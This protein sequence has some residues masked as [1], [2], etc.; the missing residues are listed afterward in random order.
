MR[1]SR[2]QALEEKVE[3]NFKNRYVWSP[4]YIDA[5]VTRDRDTDANGTLDERLFPQHDANFNVT[6]IT[7]TSGTVQ[8][9]YTPDPFGVVT[10]RNASGNTISASAKDWVFLHQGG[11]ADILGHYDFRNR[12]L[13][14]TLGRWL[15]ND[16]LGFEAGDNN[17]Y[18][19]VANGPGN[20]VD[21]SGLQ[22]PW[23]PYPYPASPLPPRPSPGGN[24]P[25]P[26]GNG[27]SG[28]DFGEVKKKTW[29][30]T[31]TN[32]IPPTPFSDGIHWG[33]E[34]WNSYAVLD[35]NGAIDKKASGYVIQHVYVTLMV[36]SYFNQPRDGM[37]PLWKPHEVAHYYE[38]IK[39][40][41][42]VGGPDYF[43]WGIKGAASTKGLFIAVG[44]SKFYF[45][46]PDNETSLDCEVYGW[47]INPANGKPYID[48]SGRV[49]GHQGFPSNTNPPP[50]WDGDQGG[51]TKT[52]SLNWSWPQGA[53][54]PTFINPKIDFSEN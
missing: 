29:R 16:P 50:F 11:Q 14:P 2:W 17:F 40:S 51:I 38:A 37:P 43:R 54:A 19:Y 1:R 26:G 15:T 34:Q 46:R 12:I 27:N 33:I 8:E 35:E 49:T 53:N 52:L 13:S 10:F 48:H 20:T 42:G 21:P 28:S 32:K 47:G 5:L 25:N 36:T 6:A 31:F 18:G 24:S 9:R 45:D 41:N 23:H 22:P 39:V 30:L 3:A 44:I 4:S 7:N